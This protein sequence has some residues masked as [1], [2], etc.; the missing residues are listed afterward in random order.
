MKK[1][2][3]SKEFVSSLSV[4][5]SQPATYE[6]SWPKI[7]IVMPTFNQAA[8]IEKSLLSVFNQGYPNLELIVI[9]GGSTDGT[10]E[11]IEKY[12]HLLTY[13]IS[14]P[15][16]GQSDALNK[17]FRQATGDIVGWL[18]SDD[19]YLPG[20]FFYV[21]TAFIKNPDKGIVFGDRVL[22]DK[23]DSVMDYKYSF[24][25]NLD[26]HKYE[27][28]QFNAQSMLWRREVHLR[29][30][31]FDIDLNY[32]MDYELILSIGINEG[33]SSFLRVHKP[34]CGFRRYSGQ[35]TGSNSSVALREHMVIAHKYGF[36]DKYNRLGKLKRLR[37]RLRRA[38]WYL[39]RG[40]VE[41]FFKRLGA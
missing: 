3:L 33:E 19:L 31:D 39:K 18:N 36:A 23:E 17:G 22:L 38:Y 7:S 32:T 14:E 20:V 11:I 21:A 12:Q 4:S 1:I 26:H 6:E 13:K 5:R 27:G 35:K 28:F 24:D 10:L 41:E 16:R 8:F 25:F 9:D 2:D 34:I 37:F 40:G 30:G 15:D 29:F